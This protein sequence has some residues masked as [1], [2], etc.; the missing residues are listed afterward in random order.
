[1]TVLDRSIQPTPFS[2]LA[3][4]VLTVSHVAAAQFA[5]FVASAVAGLVFVRAMGKPEY[6]LY[7]LASNSIFVFLALSDSGIAETALA[8]GGRQW[9]DGK[10]LGQILASAAF[11]KRRFAPWLLAPAVVLQG[12]LLLH[13]GASLLGSA[14]LLAGALIAAQFQFAAELRRVVLRLKGHIAALQRTDFV[15]ALSRAGLAL[16]LAAVMNVYVAIL[17]AVVCAGWLSFAMRRRTLTSVE[18]EAPTGPISSEMTAVIRKRR[19]YEVATIYHSQIMLLLVGFAGGFDA[20]ADIGALGRIAAFF[21]ILDAMVRSLVLPRFARCQEPRS[22]LRLYLGSLA[23]CAAAAAIPVLAAILCPTPFLW[24]L[25]ESYRGLAHELMLVTLYAGTC[26]LVGSVWALNNVRIWVVPSWANIVS[27]F[28]S[29]ALV[30]AVI[31]I[32][33]VERMLWVGIVSN[34]AVLSLNVAAAIVFSGRLRRH[35]ARPAL[36]ASAGNSSLGRESAD[37]D[38]TGS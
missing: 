34:I 4:R 10:H 38:G 3:R 8:I 31:G 16:L 11:V 7:T 17:I 19:A 27:D 15:C 33:T 9:R 36:K 20:V 18:H 2:R 32:G 37:H 5:V 14:V 22:L 30:I 21:T 1:M 24:L 26:S 29:I 23:A 12:Y 25:G 35:G 6:A 13:N 28:G